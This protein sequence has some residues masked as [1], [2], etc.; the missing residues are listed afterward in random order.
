MSL[1]D[2]LYETPSFLSANSNNNFDDDNRWSAK[3]VGLMKQLIETGISTAQV[4]TKLS[5]DTGQSFTR[6]MVI[7]KAR[8]MDIPLLGLRKS[9]TAS[10]KEKKTKPVSDR[11]VKLKKF[12]RAAPTAMTLAEVVANPKLLT[13]LEISSGQC[14]W[15]TSH[16]FDLSPKDI[17]FCGHPTEG[18]D[19]WCNAHKRVGYVEP[20]NRRYG[21]PRR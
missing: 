5:R 10:A 16:A 17:R 14:Y 11:V 9:S 18:G 15:P 4:A 19:S 1:Y 8:R 7:G 6:N 12:A 13:I 20:H 3:N 21:F 2:G